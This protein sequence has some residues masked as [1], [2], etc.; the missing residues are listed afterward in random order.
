MFRPLL[1]SLCLTSTAL[2]DTW[3]IDD[4]GKADFDNIQTAVDA[5]EWKRAAYYDQSYAGTWAL[6]LGMVDHLAYDGYQVLDANAL[7]SWM[8]A[9]I[10]NGEASVVVFCQDAAPDTVAESMD[11]DCTLRRYLDAG[12]KIIWYGDIPL[13][14]QGHEDGT[15]TFWGAAGSLAVLGFNAA[16][17]LWN[18][19]AEV[20]IT[21]EGLDWGLTENWSSTRPAAPI[22]GGLRVLAFDD[23]GYPAA[24]VKHYVDGDAYRGFVRTYDAIGAP[25]VDD[26]R[27]LAV[28]PDPVIPLLGDNLNEA[29]DDIIG[30]FTYPWYG[31][32]ATSGAWNHWQ[33]HGHNPPSTWYAHY[34]PNYP[35]STWDPSTMLY[36]SGDVALMRWQDQLMARSGLDIAISSW[37][38]IG[39]F[40]DDL[41]LSS[42]RI[43]KSV[44]WCIYYEREAYADPTALQIYTDLKWVIDRLGPTKNY[45]KVDGKWLV[46]V[47][48]AL[49]SGTAE[50]WRQ[51]KQLLHDQGYDVYIN[52]YGSGSP[53]D[54]PDPWD[55]IH[56]YNPLKRQTLTQ[57]IPAGDDS[58][59]VSPGFWLAD[60]APVLSRDLD[61]FRSAWEQTVTEAAQSRFLLIETWNEW[62]E[63]TCI[64]PGQR[65]VHDDAN[66]FSPTGDNYGLDYIDAIAEQANTLRWNTSGHR[67]D[68]PVTLEAE[69]MVWELGSSA[70]G[71]DAW[72]ISSNSTRIGA[73]VQL[74]FG[75]ESNLRITVRARG[76]QVNGPAIWPDMVLFWGGD[77]LTT[78]T[79]DSAEYGLYTYSF[80]TSGGVKTLEIGLDKTPIGQ[81]DVDIVVD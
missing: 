27:R 5:V 17:G 50:R 44:Q 7:K 42:A 41:L 66:G 51:A 79:L 73:S 70:E 20:S 72:R 67:P 24:W 10:E 81:G 28:Y 12:G 53:L 6:A 48:F 64:E 55:A 34:A 16:G 33:M 47:Y 13:Y 25:N 78:W 49:E 8:D 26:I 58:A 11:P 56:V 21:A 23:A 15:L 39:T 62:H 31:N 77:P 1:I 68:V 30:A 14:Y 80:S 38:G 9:R 60:A 4:D 35:N 45:A 32:P 3:T 75:Q 76:V 36:D 63:G 57:T 69:T 37:W 74:P 18:G 61:A 54:M 65:V 29:D 46:F 59:S 52:A 22:P 19:A 71:S 2:A 40:E 43:C